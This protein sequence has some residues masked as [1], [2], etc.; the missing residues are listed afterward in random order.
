MIIQVFVVSTYISMFQFVNLMVSDKQLQREYSDTNHRQQTIC[1]PNKW[2]LLCVM[3]HW[4]RWW[5][6]TLHSLIG[7][8]E[9]CIIVSMSLLILP[10]LLCSY[11]R[12]RAELYQCSNITK[13]FHFSFKKLYIFTRAFSLSFQSDKIIFQ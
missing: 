3:S 12:A 13:V 9:R 8:I 1:N 2:Q 4:T 7:N 11:T 6:T 5:L 10:L